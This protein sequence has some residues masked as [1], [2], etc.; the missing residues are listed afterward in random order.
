[1]KYIPIDGPAPL[2]EYP[3]T[4]LE[5]SISGNSASFLSI[6]CMIRFVSCNELPGL[7][8]RLIIKEAT[9]SS[10]T[11][12][13]GVAFIRN[14]NAARPAASVPHMAHLRRTKKRTPFL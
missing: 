12:P 11:S 8:S 3:D 6:V 2:N 7:V 1:M 10:G 14:T 4:P 5:Y 13:V 9:S